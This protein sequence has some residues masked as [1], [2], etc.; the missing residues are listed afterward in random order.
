MALSLCLSIVCAFYI[1]GSCFHHALNWLLGTGLLVWRWV[2]EVMTMVD[3]C[4][5]HLV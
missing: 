5:M 4:V 2:D 3:G 1:F